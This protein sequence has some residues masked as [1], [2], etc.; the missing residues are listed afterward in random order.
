MIAS[1]KN[2]NA[3]LIVMKLSNCITIKHLMNASTHFTGWVA[4][5]NDEILSGRFRLPE[6][7]ISEY[8]HNVWWMPVR[9]PFW[10]HLKIWFLHSH[11]SVSTC[12][13]CA[14]YNHRFCT[15][16]SLYSNILY[17]DIFNYKNR[18]GVNSNQPNITNFCVI[19]LNHITPPVFAL[20][21]ESSEWRS[22][23]WYVY[24]C[25]LTDKLLI[26]L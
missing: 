13:Y 24:D 15:Q 14:W 22:I 23:S 7:S 18:I 21:I 25:I 20:L 2:G 5:K 4:D 3:G 6:C 17:E 1:E 26:T 16:W 9:K 11:I 10:Y 12:M 8:E 19:F